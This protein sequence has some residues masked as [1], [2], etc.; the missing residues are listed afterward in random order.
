MKKKFLLLI[1][2]C[3][4]FNFLIA[5]EKISD[6]EKLVTISK[7]YGFLKYYHPEVGKG[8]YDWDK[9]FIKY[10]PQVLEASDT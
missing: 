9:E 8:K 4:N 1:L 2:I 6:T 5:Q 7:I 10:L 3:F